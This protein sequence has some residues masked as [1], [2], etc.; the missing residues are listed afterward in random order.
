VVKRSIGVRDRALMD[1][2]RPHLS[3]ARAWLLSCRCPSSACI[4]VRRSSSH[5]Q[6]ADLPLDSLVGRNRCRRDPRRHG[7]A[8]CAA[9]RPFAHQPIQRTC[10]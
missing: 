9:R 3:P 4:A 6:V 1:E 7:R 10:W 8:S 2:P 5:H